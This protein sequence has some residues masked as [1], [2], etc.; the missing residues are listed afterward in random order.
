MR[1]QRDDVVGAVGRQAIEHV[2]QIDVGIMAVE[3]YRSNQAHDRGGPLPGA[4]RRG[5]QPIRAPRRPRANLVFQS[6]VVRALQRHVRLVGANPT[7]LTLAPAGSARGG[8]GGNEWAEAFL[9]TASKEVS[10]LCGPQGE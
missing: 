3:L 2:F 10:E 5:E 8:P 4:Q 6:I 1:Q 7:R 9:E